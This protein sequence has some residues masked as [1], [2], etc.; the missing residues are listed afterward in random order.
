M[1]TA[2]TTVPAHIAARIAA[3]QQAG[4]KSAISS[5]ILGEGGVSYPRIS[6]KA[7]RYRLVEGGVETTVGITLDTIIVGANPRVSKIFYGQAYDAAAEG[8]RPA[9]F[10]NDGLRPDSS[11]ESPVHTACATCPNNV[12]GSKVLPSGA[13]SKLCADQRHLA[14]VAAADPT[15]VYSLTVPVS[16][17]KA[18]REYLK[19]LDNYGIIPEEAITQLGFDDQASYPKITFTQNGYVSEKAAA[20]V[21]Q[22]AASDEAKIATRQMDPREAA[23]GIAAPEAKAAI[24]APVAKPAAPAVDDAYEDE[25][26]AAPVAAAPAK[27]AKP[28]VAPVK[29]SSELESKLDSLFDE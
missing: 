7:G 23:P 4:T 13:K 20:R 22:L 8:V 27:P 12:L 3:R 5:A 2:L 6:I 19:E 14:V 25:A 1:S 24:A 28:A 11:V 26:E 17:M 29:A 10:S 16:G 15:K 18:M 9:C 21:D